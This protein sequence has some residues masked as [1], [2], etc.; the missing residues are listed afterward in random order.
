MSESTEMAVN[1][2][3]ALGARQLAGILE[4][5]S[6]ER[7]QELIA[8]IDE[9]P[10]VYCCAAG[11]SL[12]MMRCMAM[13][14]MHMGYASY[15]VGDTTPQAFHEG[16]LLICAS[17]SGTTSCVLNVARKARDLGGRVAC[18]TISED[19][20]LA[21][22]SDVVVSVPTFT[23]KGDFDASERTVMAGGSS[24]EHAVLLL[25]D[26]MVVPMAAARGFDINKGFPLHANLE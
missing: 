22:L 1:Q 14:L 2:I 10:H 5:V 23:D 18:I 9:A 19:S 24:F 12:L 26:A 7:L 8:L 3:A 11:R 6:G 21:E 15:V 17:G 13:R 20:P 25:S 4:G 16:D